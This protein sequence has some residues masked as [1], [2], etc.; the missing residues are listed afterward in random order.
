MCIWHNVCHLNEYKWWERRR[1]FYCYVWLCCGHPNSVQTEQP[2]KINTKGSVC[3]YSGRVRDTLSSSL[4]FYIVS[5]SLGYCAYTVIGIDQKQRDNQFQHQSLSYRVDMQLSI[6][7][8]RRAWKSLTTAL[9]I[10]PFVCLIDQTRTQTIPV[11][12]GKKIA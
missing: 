3:T 6:R 10:M 5:F 4:S 1:M 11:I 2:I 7:G 9:L 12:K 8:F